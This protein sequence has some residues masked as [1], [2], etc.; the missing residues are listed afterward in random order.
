M[1]KETKVSYLSSCP[2]CGRTLLRGTP[3]SCIEI[4]CPKCR[5]YLKV[6]FHNTGFRVCT[7]DRRSD[8]PAVA[9]MGSEAKAT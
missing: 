8:P 5:E 9:C 1:A 3:D 7:M 4:G 6:E 2:V